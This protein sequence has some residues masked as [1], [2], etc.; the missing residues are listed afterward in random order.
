MEA[1]GMERVESKMISRR[2]LIASAGMAGAAALLFNTMMGSA[3]AKDNAHGS[4]YGQVYGGGVSE[5]EPLLELDFVIATT[6]AELRA[7]TA[8][9]LDYVC[10]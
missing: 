4:V 1:I 3:K 9:E 8:P 10:T 6:I 7:N 2:K 5:L